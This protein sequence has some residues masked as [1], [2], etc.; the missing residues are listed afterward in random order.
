MKVVRRVKVKSEKAN[1]KSKISPQ[2]LSRGFGMVN[3]LLLRKF[4]M[5]MLPCIVFQPYFFYHFK[6]PFGLRDDGYG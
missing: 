5:I 6:S 4:L 3:I 2:S 1:G